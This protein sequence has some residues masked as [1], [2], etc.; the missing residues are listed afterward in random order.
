M[1]L[2]VKFHKLP[3]KQGKTK[4]ACG[5]LRVCGKKEK[6]EDNEMDSVKLRDTLSSS[7]QFPCAPHFKKT[8]QEQK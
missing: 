4:M 1:K 6:S 3:R 5:L 8:K 2:P 7:S